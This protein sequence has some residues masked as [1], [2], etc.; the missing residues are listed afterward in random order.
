[1]A[2]SIRSVIKLT[3][4]DIPGASLV[5]RLLLQLK[6]EELKFWLLCRGDY[7]KGLKTKAE[8]VKR[9]L[10]TCRLCSIKFYKPD[11]SLEVF[12]FQVT[13]L[14]NYVPFKVFK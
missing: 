3:K 5:G 14:L 7:C 9:W 13:N 2:K 11:D 6:I 4:E 12:F 1:M 10:F 8:F